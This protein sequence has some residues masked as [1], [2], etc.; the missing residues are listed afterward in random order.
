[1]LWIKGTFLPSAHDATI[2]ECKGSLHLDIPT[3]EKEITDSAC[4]ALNEIFVHPDGHSKEMTYIKY[5]FIL[6]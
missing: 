6:S 5:L 4:N 3:E 2:F 1:M